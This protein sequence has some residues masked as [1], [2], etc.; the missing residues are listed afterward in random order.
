MAVSVNEDNFSELFPTREYHR[1]ALGCI[2]EHLGVGL[3]FFTWQGY[4]RGNLPWYHGSV[5]RFPAQLV[6]SLDMDSLDV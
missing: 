6:V 2:I 1:V 3:A 4:R 5:T